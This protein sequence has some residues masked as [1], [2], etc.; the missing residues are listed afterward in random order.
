MGLLKPGD[1]VRVTDQR[2]Q[3]RGRVGTVS[4]VIFDDVYVHFDTEGH[5][6]R[7]VARRHLFNRRDLG[8]TGK[9]VKLQPVIPFIPPVPVPRL[10][11]AVVFPNVILTWP[12][13]TWALRFLVQFA[14]LTEPA[15]NDF[16][17]IGTV[18]YN[19]VAMYTHRDG[20]TY[21]AATY[22]VV[23]VRGDLVAAPSPVVEFEDEYL[24]G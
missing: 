14:P 2:S 3:Y 20:A 16:Q 9:P 11:L 23:A 4:M 12:K 13:G 22:R 18:G 24:G 10:S 15:E 1:R 21:R 19:S 8:S 17:T 7:R 5:Y 6:G